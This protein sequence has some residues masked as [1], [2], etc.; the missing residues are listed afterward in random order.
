MTNF[1]IYYKK[2][3]PA[4][5]E[6]TLFFELV[7]FESPSNSIELISDNPKPY[8]PVI[9][10]FNG[11]SIPIPTIPVMSKEL[12]SLLGPKTSPKLSLTTVPN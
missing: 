1:Y 7:S 10:R 5:K 4:V 3:K 6:N 12:K 9:R 2:L 8:L 11:R